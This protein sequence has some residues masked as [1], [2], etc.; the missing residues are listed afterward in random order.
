MADVINSIE[1]DIS[2]FHKRIGRWRIQSINQTE[3]N[4]IEYN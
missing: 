2:K 1:Y 3:M 4:Q